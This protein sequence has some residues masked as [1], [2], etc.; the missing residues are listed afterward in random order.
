MDYKNFIFAAI[1]ATAL[2][3]A[4]DASSAIDGLV[5]EYNFDEGPND[6]LVIDTSGNH[7]DAILEDTLHYTKPIQAPGY[8]SGALYFDGTNKVINIGD[9]DLLDLHRFTNMAWIKISRDNSDLTIANGGIAALPAVNFEVM[10]KLGSYWLYVERKSGLLRAGGR[11][12]PKGNCEREKKVRVDGDI[13]EREVWTHV[14]SSYDGQYLRIFINGKF[15]RQLYVPANSK[16]DTDHPLT[17]G[18]KYTPL[19]VFNVRGRLVSPDGV[20]QNPMNGFIDEVRIY[21]HALSA[22]EIQEV[23]GI[24]GPGAGPPSA[25]PSDIPKNF[26]GTSVSKKK[27]TLS[28]EGVDGVRGYTIQWRKGSSRRWKR[29]SVQAGT[30]SFTHKKLKRRTVYQYR[31]RANGSSDAGGSSDWSSIISVKTIL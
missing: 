14:A 27:I 29:I 24:A 7:I 19:P 25:E 10:E 11:F 20:I 5:L 16:C 4:D 15:K 13:I 8:R 9:N 1:A 22:N 31:I 28:W 21:D 30:T 17:V 6:S 18:A 3:M 26:T 12:D 2:G 23:M